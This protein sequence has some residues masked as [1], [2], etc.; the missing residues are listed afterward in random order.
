MTFL[1]SEHSGGM[2]ISLY[3]FARSKAKSAA[4]KTFISMFNS[5]VDVLHYILEETGEKC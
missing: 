5:A 3:W 1:W 2:A 4:L